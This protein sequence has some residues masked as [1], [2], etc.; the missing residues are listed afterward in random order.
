MFHPPARQFQAS[1]GARLGATFLGGLGGLAFGVVNFTRTLTRTIGSLPEKSQFK[2]V[3]SQVYVSRPTTAALERE[4]NTGLAE[5]VYASMTMSLR[6]LRH[7]LLTSCRFSPVLVT[8]FSSFS[9]MD[10]YPM[11][12]AEELE[13]RRLVREAAGKPQ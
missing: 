8:L 1:R 3:A 13:N 10:R 2:L 7:Q 12:A 6:L 4:T 11:A 5:P 9:L